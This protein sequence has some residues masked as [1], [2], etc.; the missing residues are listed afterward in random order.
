MD[1][2][3]NRLRHPPTTSAIEERDGKLRGLLTSVGMHIKNNFS[4]LTSTNQKKRKSDEAARNSTPPSSSN[5][6]RKR[7]SKD[8]YSPVVDG[9][10]IQSPPIIERTLIPPRMIV[11]QQSQDS[12]CHSLKSSV[13]SITSKSSISHSK[14]LSTNFVAWRQLNLEEILRLEKGD[15]VIIVIPKNDNNDSSHIKMNREN[16]LSRIETVIMECNP[17]LF[18]SKNRRKTMTQLLEANNGVGPPQKKK[19]EIYEFRATVIAYP[20]RDEFLNP[21]YPSALVDR[22]ISDGAG[23]G[24]RLHDYN[25]LKAL[26]LKLVEINSVQVLTPLFRGDERPQVLFKPGKRNVASL[27]DELNDHI[28]SSKHDILRTTEILQTFHQYKGAMLK[29]ELKRAMSIA[30]K[31]KALLDTRNY[32]DYTML[33]SNELHDDAIGSLSRSV[34]KHYKDAMEIHYVSFNQND[35]LLHPRIRDLIYN[36]IRE[37]FPY[38]YAALHSLIFSKRSEID[39][40][41]KRKSFEYKRIGLINQFLGMCRMRNPDHLIYWAMVGTLAIHGK[42]V[43]KIVHRNCIMKAFSTSICTALKHANEIYDRTKDERMALIKSQPVGG[44]SLDN[45]N[46]YHAKATQGDGKAGVYHTGMVFNLVQ[47]KQ[48]MLPVGTIVK[49][50]DS[51]RYSVLCCIIIDPYHLLLTVTQ[52][53]ENECNDASGNDNDN[54]A[55]VQDHAESNVSNDENEGSNAAVESNMQQGTL[56][57][58][59]PAIGWTIESMPGVEKPPPLTYLDQHIPAPLR[60]RIPLAIS[61]NALLMKRRHFATE[62]EKQDGILTC[63]RYNNLLKRRSKCLDIIKYAQMMKKDPMIDQYYHKQYDQPLNETASHEIKT[64]ILCKLVDRSNDEIQC[65][66]AFRDDMVNMMNVNRNVV[67]RYILFPVSP[68]DEMSTQQ[69]LLASI[70]IHE[71]LGLVDKAPRDSYATAI[72]AEYRT[73]IQYGDV[74]TD[75]K[76]YSLELV[77]LL[78]LTQIGQEDY[79]KVVHGAMKRYVQQHD[80]LHENIHRLQLIYKLYYGGFLQA[81]QTHI[82]MK[83]VRFD[84]TK[85]SWSDHESLSIRVYYALANTRVKEFIEQEKAILVKTSSLCKHEESIIEL[86]DKYE[87]F[88]EKMET[89]NCEKTRMAALYMKYTE[90][91]MRC[92]ESVGSG[93]AICLE[94]EGCEWLPLWKTMGKSKYTVSCLRRIEALYSSNLELLELIRHNRFVRLSE[95]SGTIS[96]DDFC[97]KENLSVKHLPPTPYIETVVDTSK[98]IH[99]IERCGNEF[100]GQ[101]QW[102]SRTDVAGRT[103]IESLMEL[104]SKA[105]LFKFPDNHYTLK[106]NSIWKHVEIKIVGSGCAKDTMKGVSAMN[107]HEVQ[108]NR[109]FSGWRDNGLDE[110]WNELDDNDNIKNGDDGSC[111]GYNDDLSVGST[112]TVD[113]DF[114]SGVGQDTAVPEDLFGLGVNGI[115]SIDND[116]NGIETEQAQHCVT[117]EEQENALK[118]LGNVKRY[119]IDKLCLQYLEAKGRKELKKVEKERADVLQRIK[120]RIALIFKAVE[121]FKNNMKQQIKELDE[122]MELMPVGEVQLSNWEV[123][124]VLIQAVHEIN[125]SP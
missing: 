26:D 52:I 15:F 115:G 96:Y 27:Y 1:H 30:S 34:D 3:I 111:A 22:H 14:F 10:L 104:F 99:L 66:K 75:D 7:T 50:R 19:K 74:M 71:C 58:H 62:P 89:A 100:F 49:S 48:F 120:R 56:E 29:E 121:Y 93:D 65:I 24:L 124:I 78:H 70:N 106:E 39:S 117:N 118:K 13:S 88:C 107:S 92:R 8:S 97:E 68:R 123:D 105:E 25:C 87:E 77:V 110:E 31:E 82:G 112:R 53:N 36:K 18:T 5:A 69:C 23:I 73:V 42:G 84:P 41:N 28:L 9:N 57:I 80:Y 102:K 64:S 90:S 16:F 61:D 4:W 2:L 125:D 94:V 6:K 86:F 46:R 109:V 114:E 43:P 20:N 54:E 17:S 32:N 12:S 63:R 108:F 122:L 101:K 119:K 35:S 95:D 113:D 11:T 47:M 60:F 38:H 98:H 51:T 37:S 103:A 79:V 72:N 44:H 85:G 91:W 33:L 116:G 81:C 83:K 55:E 45:Y 76:W 40:R 59:F 21:Y 67:D